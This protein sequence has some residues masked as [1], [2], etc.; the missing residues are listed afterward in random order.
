M[1]LIKFKVKSE[2]GEI[3]NCSVNS[4]QIKC[5]WDYANGSVLELL[6]GEKIVLSG[7]SK[8]QIEDE[9]EALT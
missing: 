5:I 3:I 1:K 2:A 4:S 7:K 6:S 9:L 8:K